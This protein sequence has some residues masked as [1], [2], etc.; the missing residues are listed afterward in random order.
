MHFHV[1]VGS[2]NCSRRYSTYFEASHSE[3]EP[4]LNSSIIFVL[5]GSFSV[6]TSLQE[7]IKIEI[8]ALFLCSFYTHMIEDCKKVCDYGLNDFEE[9]HF[10]SLHLECNLIF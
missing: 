2:G 6:F 3:T 5:N 1:F 9:T 4:H 7:S 10:R 8:F